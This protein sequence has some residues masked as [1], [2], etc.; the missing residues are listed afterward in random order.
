MRPVITLLSALIA[1]LASIGCQSTSQPSPTTPLPQRI[2][3]EGRAPTSFAVDSSLWPRLPK[4]HNLEFSG[5]DSL[6]IIL[7]EYPADWQAYRI[8]QE[9]ATPEEI[10]QGFYR[11]KNGL[12]FHHGPFLGE[13][14]HGRSALIPAS[15][16]QER[17]SFGGEDLF[18][19]PEV[20]RSFPIA[21]QVPH[22]E[23][24]LTADFL[25]WS[26]ADTVF[27]MSYTCHGDTALVFRGKHPVTDSKAWF[28]HWKGTVDTLKWSGEWR[29]SGVQDPPL[30]LVFWI[31][32]G[33][34]LGVSGCFDDFLAQEYAE[35]MKK[36]AVLASDP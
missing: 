28:S 35:K 26:A 32:K 15:F 12:W 36:M 19:R 10:R 18:R 5:V 29:F 1:S 34:Y 25:G 3:W 7:R 31:F 16:L 22:S 23:R 9:K 8:F 21:G 24:V 6:Q 2:L 20:F 13:L 27:A 11:E 30:P 14:R 33:G 17:L 4:I